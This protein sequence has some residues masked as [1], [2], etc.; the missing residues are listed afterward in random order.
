MS[1][2][3]NASNLG[4]KE[5]AVLADGDEVTYASNGIVAD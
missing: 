5:D 2:T 1:G 4:S 3:R